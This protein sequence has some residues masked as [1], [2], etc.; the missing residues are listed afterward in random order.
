MAMVYGDY[1]EWRQRKNK[2]NFKAQT[3]LKG[4]KRKLDTGFLRPDD[5]GRQ[6]RKDVARL[7]LRQLSLILPAIPVLCRQAKIVE[8][9]SENLLIN[10]MKQK[11]SLTQ[12]QSICYKQDKWKY[13]NFSPG[14]KGNF[15]SL[16]KILLK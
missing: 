2:A 11:I 8:N 12:S 16:F 14:V 10:R 15:Y 13:L 5:D 7:V 3:T 4:V 6:M 1:I 9:R